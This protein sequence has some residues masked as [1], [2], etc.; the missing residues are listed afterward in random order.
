MLVYTMLLPRIAA[1]FDAAGVT[2]ALVGGHA[3]DV[4]AL[5][6]LR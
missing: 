4:K 6:K 3:M 1:A 5:R 2:Y